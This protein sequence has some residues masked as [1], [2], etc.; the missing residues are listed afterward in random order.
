[1]QHDS[2]RYSERPWS[3][4][5]PSS[6]TSKFASLHH[7]TRGGASA[8]V[9]GLV[10]PARDEVARLPSGWQFGAASPC[11]SGRFE[12]PGS[13]SSFQEGRKF[14]SHGR[15]HLAVVRYVRGSRLLRRAVRRDSE[16]D[17]RR[18]RC[19]S[20]AKT[21]PGA[22]SGKPNRYSAIIG[23][24][25]RDHHKLGTT[26]FEFSRDEFVDIAHSLGI[27]LPKNLGDTIYSFRFR[28]ALPPEIT[29][30]RPRRAW[31]GESNSQGKVS[32]DSSCAS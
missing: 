6:D 23:R 29:S 24:I 10:S 27:V 15:S 4:H 28:T 7:G 5:F 32:T 13:F 14:G 18:V 30:P 21:N 3:V 12:S 11:Q 19:H 1:M 25:F 31:S 20:M 16:A 2:S 9:P 17:S 22:G 8:F 26:Q